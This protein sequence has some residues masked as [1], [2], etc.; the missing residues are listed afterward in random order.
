[1]AGARKTELA[2]N[3]EIGIC[4]A[5][6]ANKTNAMF[7]QFN[8]TGHGFFL[9]LGGTRQVHRISGHTDEKKGVTRRYILLLSMSL[10]A[11]TV[12]LCLSPLA[13]GAFHVF[14]QLENINQRNKLLLCELIIVNAER[15]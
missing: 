1:M 2:Q 8:L 7:S 12:R 11:V 5:E 14:G 9:Y 13:D 15:H 6:L 10:L 4:Q 3:Y